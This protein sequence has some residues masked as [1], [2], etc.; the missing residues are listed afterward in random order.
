MDE[1]QYRLENL[2][3]WFQGGVRRSVLIFAGICL[4]L[5]API[6]F[7]AGF[8]SN[9]WA[10]VSFNS[11]QFNGTNYFSSKFI[12]ERNWT[13]SNTQVVSLKDGSREVYASINNKLNPQIGY[14]PFVYDLQVL[15]D[16][17]SV[18]F[19]ETRETYLL[20]GDV[21][22]IVVRS[23]DG[24]AGKLKIGKNNRTQAY[25]YN[26]NSK[27]YKKP[28]IRVVSTDFRVRTFT[29]DMTVLFTLK[30][31]DQVRVNKVDVV[32]TVRDSRES[33]IGI[34]DFSFED[35]KP[36]EQRDFSL[37]YTQ[38]LEREPRLITVEWSV[39]Y[40]DAKNLNLI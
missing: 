20:P 27:N 21:K 12:Q 14:S 4:I 22:F 18:L 36:G 39:N 33:V 3:I 13:V 10:G 6:Y 26:P 34:G 11:S 15:D 30:N 1:L 8:L 28:N 40:L 31:D 23:Q 5:L 9:V 24:R 37:P 38:P 19:Q 25:Y 2:A 16:N 17:N 35:F 32:F 7:L 29:N